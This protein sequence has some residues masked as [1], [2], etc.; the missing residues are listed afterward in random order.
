MLS[1]MSSFEAVLFDFSGVLTTSPWPALAASGGGDLELIVGPYHEDTDHPWHRLERGEITLEAWFVE[2]QALAAATGATF[3]L[4]PLQRLLGELV[5]HDDVVDHVAGL[6]ADGYRTALITNNVAEGSNTWRSLV[7]V[8]DLFDVVVDSSSVGMRKPD[9]AIFTH[10]L[11]LLGV[12]ATRAV[13]LD[14]VEGNLA[15]ARR[16]G[17]RTILVGDPPAGALAELD[18]LL[19]RARPGA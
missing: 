13:F 8:D 11:D 4:A 12:P 17:L 19:G 9:P 16:A 10:A 7:A 6:R 18:A 15:G 5:V 3:D 2:V 14:D 1:P